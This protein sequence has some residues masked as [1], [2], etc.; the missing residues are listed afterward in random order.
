[1]PRAAFPHFGYPDPV[2]TSSRSVAVLLLDE[3]ELPEVAALASVLAQAG[4]QWNF[5]PFK[6]TP[7]GRSA[8]P[9]ETRSQLRLEA[10]RS[11]EE[12]ATAEIVVVPGGYG[13]RKALSDDRVV[14]WLA[15]VG[16]AAAEVV[17]IG[18]GVLLVA[19]AGLADGRELA[20]TPD[21]AALLADLGTE[22]TART[23]TV[24]HES[25][26]VWS[27]A[28]AAAAAELALDLV[29]RHLGEKQA[30]LVA[31]SLGLVRGG[32]TIGIVEAAD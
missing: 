26:N 22:A 10:T 15:R 14:E 25:G 30:R 3:V 17:A 31:D 29:A 19:R 16:A 12:C 7:V 4:R 24:K 13:A 23:D 8:G 20:A 9:V 21:T 5:R 6:L 1:M 18:H 2:R 28:T 11:L 32:V 27:A